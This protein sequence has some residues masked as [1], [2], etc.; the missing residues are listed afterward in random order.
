MKYRPLSVPFALLMFFL[1]AVLFSVYSGVSHHY[2]FY[3]MWD[4]DQVVVV[5][6]LVMNKGLLPVHI[7]H[8][9]FGMYLLLKIIV[10]IAGAF[11]FLSTIN[12]SDIEH[13]LNPILGVA[14][15]SVFLRMVSAW[16][17]LA[18]VGMLWGAIAIQMQ[19]NF[20]R[21]VA[22]LVLATQ[23]SLIYHTS[24]IR[25][26]LYAIFYW[27]AAVLAVSFA[28]ITDSHKK[29]VV[30]LTLAG[31][32]AGLTY[33]SKVQA[34]FYVA[35]IPF[36]F[37]FLYESNHEISVE[38][39]KVQPKVLKRVSLFNFL[40]TIF[41]LV[42]ARFRQ[43]DGQTFTN[44]YEFNV[45]GMFFIL[46]AAG[47]LLHERMNRLKRYG[48]NLSVMHLFLLGFNLAFFI[49]FFAFLNPATSYK[50]MLM[51]AKMLFFRTSYYE[52]FSGFRLMANFIQ[53]LV[54]GVVENWP[55]VLL[56]LSMCFLW[57]RQ[58]RKSRCLS[59]IVL[60][61][62]ALSISNIS[63]GARGV[64]RD[65]LWCEVMP[66]FLGLVILATLL[67]KITSVNRVTVALMASVLLITV[68]SNA[69]YSFAMPKK[70]DANFNLYGWQQSHSF[71][72]VFAWSQLEFAN[73]MVSKYHRDRAQ[74]AEAAKFSLDYLRHYRDAEFTFPNQR[75]SLRDITQ[76]NEG[77]SVWK[78]SDAVIKAVPEAFRGA[79]LVDNWSLPTSDLFFDP[80]KMDN[81]NDSWGKVSRKNKPNT[82]ALITRSDLDVYFFTRRNGTVAS[83]SPVITVMENNVPTKYQGILI[84]NYQ[85][86]DRSKYRSPGFFVIMQNFRNTCPDA[87]GCS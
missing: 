83:D 71:D 38:N 64:L 69:R 15:L 9:G 27:S 77:F 48:I 17:A 13:S 56:V 16:I 39:V 54:R 29:R 11:H 55:A 72:A 78:D 52:G 31:I 23:S 47:L 51:D 85:E 37:V 58:Q 81:Q 50:Y 3:F 80:V 60:I 5:D 66:I 22:F 19:S 40:I 61:S 2:P 76:V 68:V 62:V 79:V 7:H 33:L 46:I 44:S 14:E 4:M 75:I 53:K 26:E 63:V 65:I 18:V 45:F 82:I 30:G 59:T 6:S 86:I 70:I 10:N 74:I 12:F 28:S 87:L 20:A 36:L 21:L 84:K 24:M 1:F 49:H 73:L 25:T 67:R 32:F 35:I 34:L 8:P 41:L 57:L 43:A 42:G